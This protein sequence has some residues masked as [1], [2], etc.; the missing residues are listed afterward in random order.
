MLAELDDAG[1]PGGMVW[2]RRP[3]PTYPN[4]RKVYVRGFA[5]ATCITAP[6]GQTAS[7]LRDRD[8]TSS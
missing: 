6:D 5:V 3:R 1:L 8:G 2:T 4:G 7:G